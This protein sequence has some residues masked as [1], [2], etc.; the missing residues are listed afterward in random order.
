MGRY[1]DNTG[2]PA[3]KFPAGVFTE[4]LLFIAFLRK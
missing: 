4:N 1:I 2:L 3:G